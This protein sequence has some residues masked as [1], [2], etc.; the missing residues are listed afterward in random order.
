MSRRAPSACCGSKTGRTQHHNH[1][2][3][4]NGTEHGHHEYMKEHGTPV[5]QIRQVDIKTN[6]RKKIRPGI[7][8]QSVKAWREMWTTAVT[9][10]L[11]VFGFRMGGIFHLPS[12]LSGPPTTSA[13]CSHQR[14]SCTS[15][16]RHPGHQ[17][18]CV[19]STPFPKDSWWAAACAAAPE[20]RTSQPQ[21][22]RRLGCH[23]A[24]HGT[25]DWK[26]PANRAS[27]RLSL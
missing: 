5:K 18:L 2:A 12:M 22:E 7:T 19:S 21:V 26:R 16:A 20:S 13:F 8:G 3:T 14:C 6:R 9:P 25:A 11:S 17:T 23:A 24:C 1:T 15:C 4:P 10:S 27:L